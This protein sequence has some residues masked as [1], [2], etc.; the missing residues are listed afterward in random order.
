ME[1][2]DFQLSPICQEESPLSESAQNTQQSLSSMSTI[3]Q[4][5]AP[6]S[7][8]QFLP[9]K[10]CPQLS[11][12]KINSGHGSLSSVFFNNMSRSSLPPYHDQT[13]TP[14]SSMGGRPNTQ[15]PPD[16]PL[17]YIPAKWRFMDKYSGSLSSSPSGPPIISQRVP[18]YKKRY[19]SLWYNYVFLPRKY[20]G[21]LEGSKFWKLIF[22]NWAETICC[23]RHWTVALGKLTWCSPSG[24]ESGGSR[25]GL[26]FHC[27]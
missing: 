27:L 3:F 20:F 22:L 9:E 26:I 6:T 2:E 17:E 21:R 8:N 18:I 23:D 16:P 12:E 25:S 7:Q 24:S 13:S 1:G 11:N 4:P 15:W 10:Y 19:V 5:L 14:L